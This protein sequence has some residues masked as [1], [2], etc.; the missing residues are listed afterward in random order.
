MSK[1]V[2][3]T[4]VVLV[5]IVVGAVLFFKGGSYQSPQ[6]DTS[7]QGNELTAGTENQGTTSASGTTA[8]ETTAKT[9]TIDI[10]NFDFSPSTLTVKVGDT[11]TWTNMDSVGHTVTSDSGS[12]L[13]SSTLSNGGSYSHTFTSAGTFSYHC[14]PH[15]TM[16]ATV[17]VQ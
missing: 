12:E 5:L 15:P 11:V 6:T 14:R 13:A 1:G 9:Y 2:W 4:I 17:T 10:K 7:Q 3:I 16:K 8:P